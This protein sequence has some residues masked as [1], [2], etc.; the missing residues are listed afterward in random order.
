M[1][2]DAVKKFVFNRDGWRCRHCNNGNGL[3][4]HHVIYASA[5]GADEPWNLITLCRVCH[6]SIHAGRL[7]LEILKVEADNILVKFWKQKG[8]KP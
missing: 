2:S 8:W 3:D 5:G 7:K 4:P 6:D 1:I